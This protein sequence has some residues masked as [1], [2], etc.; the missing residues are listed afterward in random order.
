MDGP[1]EAASIVSASGLHEALVDRQVVA[2]G[3]PP[4]GLGGAVVRVVLQDVVVDA[5]QDEAMVGALQQ[6]LGDHLDVGRRGF[7]G[8]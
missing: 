5:S 7:L 6:R 8:S 2:Y 3:V 1:V 4:G